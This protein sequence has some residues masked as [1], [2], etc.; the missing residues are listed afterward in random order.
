MATASFFQNRRL[1]RYVT[2][3]Y[4]LLLAY[5]SLSPGQ[6]IP[7]IL[8]WSELFSPDKVAHFGAYAVFTVLLTSS[9]GRMGYWQRVGLATVTAATFGALMEILQGVSGTGREYDPVDMVAN[10]LG[11]LLG[12]ALYILFIKFVGRYRTTVRT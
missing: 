9:L 1:Q 7:G 5:L 2:A 11:A 10:L 12:A 6:R 3:G 8:D 4:A